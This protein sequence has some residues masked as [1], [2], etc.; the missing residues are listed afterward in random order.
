MTCPI[1][2]L[3]IS[4]DDAKVMQEAF[5]GEIQRRTKHR[6]VNN[7][8]AISN[9]ALARCIACNPSRPQLPLIRPPLL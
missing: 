9:S 1:S 6:T 7:E 2:Y 4:V 3:Y 8:F 5:H